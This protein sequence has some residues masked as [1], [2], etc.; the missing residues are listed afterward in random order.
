MGKPDDGSAQ[1]V[2]RGLTGKE[3]VGALHRR[4]EDGRLVRERVKKDR[5][6]MAAAIRAELGTEINVDDARKACQF[7][8][9]FN[10]R[11]LKWLCALCLNKSCRPISWKHVRLVLDL[12][13]KQEVRTLLERAAR[14]GWPAGRLERELRAKSDEPRS[15]GGPQF[16]QPADLDDALKQVAESTSGWLKR[17]LNVWSNDAIWVPPADLT[18]E[19]RN[20]LIG[21]V[22]H[23]RAH[24]I[25]LSQGAQALVEKLKCLEKA[26]ARPGNSVRPSRPKS[27]E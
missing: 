17:F 15:K 23:E 9:I 1:H 21:A 8:K 12:R 10:K 2:K 4:H 25:D 24:L 7:A 13:D 19:C 26:L 14:S 18:E 16:R 5:C 22:R 3:A 11:D 20:A 27:R 6:K